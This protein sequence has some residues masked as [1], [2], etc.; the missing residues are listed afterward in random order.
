MQKKLINYIYRNCYKL[1]LGSDY[2]LIFKARKV[3][4]GLEAK[5][6]GGRKEF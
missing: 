5:G 1:L 4:Q 2:N 3:V 6:V